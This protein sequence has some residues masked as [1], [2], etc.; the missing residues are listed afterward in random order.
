MRNT[1]RYRITASALCYWSIGVVGQP[2][3]GA[4]CA[5]VVADFYAREDFSDF[6][7]D[8]KLRAIIKQSS[9]KRNRP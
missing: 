7:R 5:S 2:L 9:G 4:N 1:A 6:R 8:L 3:G